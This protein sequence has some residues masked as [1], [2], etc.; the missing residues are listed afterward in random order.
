M[1]GEIRDAEMQALRDAASAAI[2]EC[3]ASDKKANILLEALLLYVKWGTLHENL[4][5]PEDD[6]CICFVA[7][8]VNTAIAQAERASIAAEEG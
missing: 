5:C 1:K 7:R 6:T 4:E 3:V 8:K 2:D